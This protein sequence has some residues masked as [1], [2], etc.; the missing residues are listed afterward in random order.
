MG[1]WKNDAA[2]GHF[3]GDE[4]AAPFCCPTPPETPASCS[5]G[6]VVN[7][8]YVQ[9][10]HRLCPDVYAYAYDDR[11]GL[12]TCPAGTKYEMVYHCPTKRSK[13]GGP[14]PAQ[15]PQKKTYTSPPTT[16]TQPDTTLPVEVV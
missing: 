1:N 9:A 16:T 12:L 3:P 13:S 15:P 8:S 14:G 4:V 6:P 2:N 10:M 7:T 11:M 5:S